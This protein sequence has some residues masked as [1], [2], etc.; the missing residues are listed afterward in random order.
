M[1][2][3]SMQRVELD[4]TAPNALKLSE[5]RVT[6]RDAET[7]ADILKLVSKHGFDLAFSKTP[8]ADS[9]YIAVRLSRPVR[10]ALREKGF[11]VEK[12]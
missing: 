5:W 7:T 12:F 11:V 4:P 6:H 10:D 8:K 2:G 1:R 9:N 3:V